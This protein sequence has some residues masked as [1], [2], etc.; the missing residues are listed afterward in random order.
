MFRA[1]IKRFFIND[2]HFFDMKEEREYCLSVELH[3]Y[4]GSTSAFRQF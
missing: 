4:D 1:I 3:K 2:V